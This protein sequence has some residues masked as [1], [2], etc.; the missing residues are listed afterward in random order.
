MEFKKNKDYSTLPPSHILFENLS[1]TKI[2][3]S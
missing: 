3:G 1:K 2:A